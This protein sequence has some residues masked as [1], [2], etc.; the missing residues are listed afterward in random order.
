MQKQSWVKTII[1]TAVLTAC[2]GGQNPAA[3]TA[4]AAA[5]MWFGSIKSI[6]NLSGL[7]SEDGL[8]RFTTP[9]QH[10]SGETKYT[11][12]ALT[13]DWDVYTLESAVFAAKQGTISINAKVNPKLNVVGSYTG[14]DN[15]MIFLD[16]LS[17]NYDLPSTPSLISGN[18]KFIQL[19]S[20]GLSFEQ[21]FSIDGNG[22]L[23]GNDT[24][25]CLYTGQINSMNPSKNIYKSKLNITNCGNLNGAYL[26]LANYGETPANP[27]QIS[28]LYISVSNKQYSMATLLGKI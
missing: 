28:S 21:N 13:A 22:I 26:G 9:I 5:G 16:A 17:Q 11:N 3:P 15:G 19:S 25:G 6:N 10:F 14:L 1:F 12:N 2:G 23:T 24:K 18:W 4:D 8:M 7:I 20:E 27:G